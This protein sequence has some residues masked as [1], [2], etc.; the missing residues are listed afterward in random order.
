MIK[1]T[2]KKIISLGGIEIKKINNKPFDPIHLWEDEAVFNNFY[3]NITSNTVVDKKRCFMLFQ[4]INQS[5]TLDGDIAEIGVYRGG[6]AKL[7]A[8][9]I[10]SKKIN[11]DINLFDTFDGMPETLKDKDF[12]KKGDFSTTSLE[13]VSKYL[14][15]HKQIKYYKGIFPQ[16]SAPIKDKVFSFIHIDVD[17]YKSVL[18][19][20]EFF[21]SRMSKG[22][23]MIFDDYGF[24]SCPGAKS[25]VDEFF[26]NK[27]EFPIYLP[28]GQCLVVKI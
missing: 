16:T 11:K 13:E 20:C 5:L 4:L 15:S 10:E 8:Q 12:H 19:C 9:I 3:K 21:Y 28:T 14:N 18:D 25:A 7:F 22:G 2:L 1:K 27:I 26:K 6:T 17:I 23:I 24:V